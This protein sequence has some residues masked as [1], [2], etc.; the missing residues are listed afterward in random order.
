MNLYAYVNGNPINFTDPRGLDAPG[1]DRV[2]D[3]LETSC[4]RICCD[5]HDQ[6]FKKHGCTEASWIDWSRGIKNACTECNQEV[7]DCFSKCAGEDTIKSGGQEVPI[8]IE[9]PFKT[10]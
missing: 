2:P 5:T 9:I 4:R 10:R 7:W 3:C 6:C 1:C 8:F